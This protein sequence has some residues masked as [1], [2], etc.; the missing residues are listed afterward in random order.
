VRRF[1]GVIFD[2]DGTLIEQS[3]DFPRVRAELGVPDSA[4]ILE[5]LAAMEP[6]EAEAGRQRLLEHEL[7][8][9]RKARLMPGAREILTR[10]RDA[11][12]KAALLTRN[13]GEA[14]AIVL[15][16]FALRF[17]LAWSREDGPIKPEPDGVLRA[18]A[19]LGIAPARTAS[20]GDF[21]YDLVAANAAGAFSILYA[22]GELPEFAEIAGRVIT[23]LAELGEILDL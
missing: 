10:I 18:C 6:D 17:D 16:R 13:A 9:V 2:M 19:E 20:V 4:G 15:E 22:P 12:I 8:G 3:I 11:G 7:A 1:D 14:M 23:D 5:T 21:R